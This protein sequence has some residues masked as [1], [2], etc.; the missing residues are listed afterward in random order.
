MD[1]NAEGTARA[2][3]L[4]DMTFAIDRQHNA[5]HLL[6][7]LFVQIRVHSWTTPA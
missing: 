4:R 6:S 5:S 7:F 3:A 1:T 2:I